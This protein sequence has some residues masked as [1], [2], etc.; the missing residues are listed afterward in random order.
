MT[1]RDKTNELMQSVI[2]AQSTIKTAA[3][4][5]QNEDGGVAFQATGALQL[6]CEKLQ[7]V[8][9]GLDKFGMEL[10]KSAAA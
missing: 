3:T 4:A 6:A 10:D 7:A 2:D 9:E 5:L 1:P 8:I